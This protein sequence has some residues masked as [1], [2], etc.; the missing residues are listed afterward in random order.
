MPDTIAYIGQITG[1]NFHNASL[2]LEALT[3]SSYATEKGC[4]CNERLEFLG[5][6]ILSIIVSDYLFHHKPTLPEGEMT[7][8]RAAVVCERTLAKC[9]REIRLGSV[10]RL[11]HGE[12]RSGGA[13]RDSVLADATEA[14]IAALYLDGGYIVAKTWVLS[15]L[16]ESIAAALSVHESRD[17]KTA[18]QERFQGKNAVLP[19]YTVL[20][21]SGPAHNRFYQVAVAVGEKTLGIGQGRSKKLAEQAAAKAALETLQ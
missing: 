14:V 16:K 6:S 10:L 9:A 18:L 20:E 1:H 7:R 11:G 5:D 12:A 8:V 3:H 13:D 21:E 19:V 4:I 2:I 17:A 15:L